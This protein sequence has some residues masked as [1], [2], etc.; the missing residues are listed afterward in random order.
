MVEDPVSDKR[1]ALVFPDLALRWKAIRIVM[2]D[3]HELQIRVTS[4]YRSYEAQL[5]LY[6][7]G[8]KQHPSGEWYVAEKKK[9]VTNAQAGESYHNF[10]LAL[11]SCFMGDDPF[12][13]KRKNGAE[14][15]NIF[16]SV[17]KELEL[18]WGGEW[19]KFPDR[20]HVEMTYGLSLANARTLHKQKGIQGIFAYC[21]NA[22]L[23]GGKYV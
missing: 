4:G 17:C 20:P 21:D 22:T 9:V 14:L 12:L 5:D 18:T 16:G 11:D 10:G 2:W 13:E 23:C 7:R 3:R 1:L 6:S 15:W 19:K 8:R